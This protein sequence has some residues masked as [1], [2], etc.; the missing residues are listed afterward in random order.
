[1]ST[2]KTGEGRD[3]P[4]DSVDSLKARARAAG[5]AWRSR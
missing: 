1:M 2:K 5:A 4:R 3:H